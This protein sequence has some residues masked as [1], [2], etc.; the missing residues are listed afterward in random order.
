MNFPKN[1]V[2]SVGSVF[3]GPIFKIVSD[4]EIDVDDVRCW[5]RNILA[6]DLAVFVAIVF[7]Y[8]FCHRNLGNVTNINI[9][10]VPCPIVSDLIY[11]VLFWTVYVRSTWSEDSLLTNY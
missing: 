11:S 7:A 3:I 9:N 2:L 6:T 1:R 5:R 8:E 4:S 10:A